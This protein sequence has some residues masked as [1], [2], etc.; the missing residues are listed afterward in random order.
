MNNIQEISRRE[1]RARI[2]RVMDYVEKNLDSPLDL[3]VLA[4]IA[5][6]SPF[7]FHR[8]FTVMTGETPGGFLQR[9][10][11]EKAASMIFK[12]SE[13][14]IRDIAYQCGFNDASSFSRTFRKHFGMTAKKMRGSPCG[15]FVKDGVR[16]S[17]DGQPVSNNCTTDAEGNAQFCGVELKNLIIMD[18][19]IEIKQMPEMKV[20]YARHT[21]AFNRIHEAYAKVSK[22][23]GPRGLIGP[24]TKTMTVYHD[25]PSV[26]SVDKV[27]QSACIVIEGDVKVEGE[28]GKMTVPGGLYAVGAFRIGVEGFEKAWNTMCNWLTESGYQPGEGN[29]YELYHK[30]NGHFPNIEFILD[31][32]IPVKPL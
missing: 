17:K 14:P 26:T 13:M 7:H 19:K 9:V 23:A 20:I 28:I 8:I 6:F 12:Q 16:F 22:W 4:G 29:H 18:T 25:D 2:N 24:D 1:Y 21:G 32:C 31:I 10:R 27:R 15:L 5:N 30:Q 3:S 11:L